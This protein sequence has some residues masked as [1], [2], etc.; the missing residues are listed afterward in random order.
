MQAFLLSILKAG[1][2]PIITTI[3]AL[4]DV[5]YAN[6]KQVV[7][8]SDNELDNSILGIV[9]EAVHTWEPKNE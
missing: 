6:L 5:L 3:Q 1:R 2:G 8:S 7:E 9:V 4:L